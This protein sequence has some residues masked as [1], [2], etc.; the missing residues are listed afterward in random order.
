MEGR[1]SFFCPVYQ[2]RVKTASSFF[3]RDNIL[4]FKE[5]PL[6]STLLCQVLEAT[7]SEVVLLQKIL[8]PPTF[9][10]CGKLVTPEPG[11]P[12]PLVTCAQMGSV[13]HQQGPAAPSL[14]PEIHGDGSSPA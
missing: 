3:L 4:E 10:G 13:L 7:H 8:F 6:P 14:F 2:G 11:S 5:F 1:G 12:P 9:S